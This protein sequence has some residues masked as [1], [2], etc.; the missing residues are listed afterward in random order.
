MH[1][2]NL[3]RDRLYEKPIETMSETEKEDLRRRMQKFEDAADKAGGY[4]VQTTHD[5]LTEEDD[6]LMHD[7]IKKTKENRHSVSK[8]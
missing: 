5:D 3:S 2:E 7:Y 1:Y 6:Q 4:V 8:R